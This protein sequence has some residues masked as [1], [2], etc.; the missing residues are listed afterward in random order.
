MNDGYQGGSTT[1]GRWGCGFALLVGIPV[2]V[3]LTLANTLGDC[4]PGAECHHFLTGAVLPTVVLTA[5]VGFGIRFAVN[6]SIRRRHESD[7]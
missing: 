4:E 7:G 5:A 2:G 6:R 1:G 3:F